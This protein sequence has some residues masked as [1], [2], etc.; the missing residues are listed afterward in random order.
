LCRILSNLQKR[1]NT[2]AS[3]T[4]SQDRN[5]KKKKP[6]TNS[7]Y[8]GTVTLIPKPHKEPTKKENFT[9]IS[10]INNN[11]K[12]FNKILGNQIQ[13]HMKTIIHHDQVRL[14]HRHTGMVQY[15][16]I[17]QYNPLYKQTKSKK[18]THTRSSH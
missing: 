6:L 13:E 5:R 11:A 18:H 7:Y 10:F 2:N 14:H 17:H 12:I 8:E 4:I 15:T 9:P 16:E 1:P 3:Q